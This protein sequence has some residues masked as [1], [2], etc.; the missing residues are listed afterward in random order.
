MQY[1]YAAAFEKSLKGLQESRK[2]RVK[3]AVQFAVAFF[4]TG[5]LPAGLGLKPLRYDIWEIRAGL[6][7]RIIFRKTKEHIIEFLIVGSH[8][9]IKR[10][11]KRL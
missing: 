4:E 1:F 11:L 6:E 9:E 5:S 3:K 8:D 2:Q 7:D 10:F